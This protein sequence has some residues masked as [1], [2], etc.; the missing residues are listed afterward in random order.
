MD[1]KKVII[2]DD[3]ADFVAALK[4]ILAAKG[5]KVFSA[6]NKDEGRKQIKELAPD[7]IILDVM[8]EN[9]SDGFDLAR[10]LKSDEDYKRIPL[11]MLTAIG[12]T[13]G[14]RYSVTAGD[15]DWLPVDEYMEKPINPEAL[16]LKVEKLIENRK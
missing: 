11:L 4:V 3:D 13:T 12:E 15:K 7:L 2:I 16:I 14:F 1:H 9:M 6:A 5:Y 10:E 8:L